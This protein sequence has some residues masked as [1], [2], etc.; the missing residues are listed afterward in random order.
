MRSD[1]VARLFVAHILGCA[2]TDQARCC[3]LLDATGIQGVGH[4]VTGS[5]S[6]PLYVMLAMP[7][8]LHKLH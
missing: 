1:C 2:I 4:S 6:T 3:C 7:V 8:T 5:L